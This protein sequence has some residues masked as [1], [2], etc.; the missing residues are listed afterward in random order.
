MSAVSA[1]LGLSNSGLSVKLIVRLPNQR[2]ICLHNNG[3]H[4]VFGP[5]EEVPSAVLRLAQ[6]ATSF[7]GRSPR[8]GAG[9]V[10]PIDSR[11]RIRAVLFDLDGTLYRQRRMR[12]LM[13][14]ELVTHALT[15]PLRA[16]RNWRALA[17]Y[18]KAQEVARSKPFGAATAQLEI[19]A[20]RTGLMPPEIEQIVGEWM[21]ERPLKH[22]PACRAAGL[23]ELLAF[24]GSK[25]IEI[26]VLSDYPAEA[27]LRALGLAGRFSVVLC[28][29]DPE[30]GALK[31]HPRGFLTACERWHIDP[32]DVLVVGDRFDVDAAGAA[33][34]GMPCVIIGRR[35]R[36]AS[37]NLGSLVL[38]SLERLRYV[39]DECC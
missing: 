24:L 15:Q 33:A 13:A 17:A 37:N 34:A 10:N 28:S 9:V 11:R 18:R 32:G 29:A 3:F 6:S 5:K 38:P 16:P 19:V 14:I 31:P 25:G 36:A 20:Q 23:F 8:A 21:F 30:I 22:L 7:T 27:K 2:V 1:L 39:L 12:A 4:Q 26:G 35:S